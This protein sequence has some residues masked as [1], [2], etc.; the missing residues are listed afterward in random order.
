M[1]AREHS[2]MDMPLFSKE[3]LSQPIGQIAFDAQLLSG[4]QQETAA[5]TQAL[6]A[7]LSD[8][9]LHK[10]EGWLDKDPVF[11]RVKAEGV[12]AVIVSYQTQE[13]FQKAFDRAV[14]DVN[15]HRGMEGRA[16]AMGMIAEKMGYIDQDVKN[17]LLTAQAG[18]RAEAFAASLEAVEL[19]LRPRVFEAD[20]P[21]LQ[22]AQG[23]L[24]TLLDDHGQRIG[25]SK[26]MAEQ[27]YQ[28][29]GTMLTRAGMKEELA[30]EI[31]APLET[32]AHS[33][34]V[35]SATVG[36]KTPVQG[37]GGE[38]GQVAW[39]LAVQDRSKGTDGVG[40]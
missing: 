35:F 19:P 9:N 23:N 38:Q 27:A 29:A 31:A 39:Q 6:F 30:P 22:K 7:A 37:V 4:E 20:P 21:E 1:A 13:R 16:P 24:I 15:A 11:T 18:A 14:V 36:M 34:Q 17:A 40:V 32:L 28:D 3:K 5:R 25:V 12:N 33:M 8:A 2:M 26:A 10:V